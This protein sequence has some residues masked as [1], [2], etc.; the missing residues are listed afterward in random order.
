MVRVTRTCEDVS[1]QVS[2]PDLGPT[3]LGGIEGGWPGWWGM[4][5]SP[6][7]SGWWLVALG[8]WGVIL[9]P[10]AGPV[11]LGPGV[12]FSVVERCRSAV[13]LRCRS[14]AHLSAVESR[15]IERFEVRFEGCFGV[16]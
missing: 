1:A 14:P 15:L 16:S 12:A 5:S 6:G 2:R 7:T 9:G 11:G 8:P 4:I 3:T 10:L 13:P